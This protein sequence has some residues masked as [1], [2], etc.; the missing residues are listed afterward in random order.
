MVWVIGTVCVCC[1][2]SVRCE[3]SLVSFVCWEGETETLKLV[4]HIDFL[5]FFF[6]K[7]FVFSVLK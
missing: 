1:S 4:K 6:F 7:G 5:D 2:H 3:D